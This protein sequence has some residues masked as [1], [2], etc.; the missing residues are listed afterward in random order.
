MD[1][2]FAG[3]DSIFL[4]M[5]NQT[6]VFDYFQLM[7]LPSP[8]AGDGGFYI[9]DLRNGGITV[10]DFN[11]DGLDDMV[12]GGVQGVAR[13]CYNKCVLVDIIRPDNA[14]IFS[15]SMS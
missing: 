7:T 5:Q 3:S 12:I 14:R 8:K 13:I 1:F 4:Y 6:G 10:G 11:G 15:N 9:D 2:V